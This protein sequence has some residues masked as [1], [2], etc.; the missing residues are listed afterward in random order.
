M[1]LRDRFRRAPAG[2]PVAAVASISEPEPLAAPKNG[3]LDE[4]QEMK[5]RLHRELVR[6]S[7]A[8]DADWTGAAARAWTQHAAA[9]GARWAR[10]LDQSVGSGGWLV[11]GHERAQ[12]LLEG[13]PGCLDAKVIRRQPQPGKGVVEAD[14]GAVVAGGP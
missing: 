7:G 8:D 3:H 14:D 9:S 13:L 6:R 4:Y 12:R 5:R 11:H 2:A 10:A 1:S